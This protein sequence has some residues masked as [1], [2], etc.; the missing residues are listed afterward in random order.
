MMV[1]VLQNI[2]DLIHQDTSPYNH[3]TVLKHDTG[4]FKDLIYPQE[5]MISST[6]KLGML[7]RLK[8][9]LFVIPLLPLGGCFPFSGVDV[10]GKRNA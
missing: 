5:S 6:A 9:D 8:F 3:S 7:K 4:I 10:I 2:K 1:S